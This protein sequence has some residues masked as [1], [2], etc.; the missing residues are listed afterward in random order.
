MSE[1]PDGTWFQY[2][3]QAS[4]GVPGMVIRS[5]ERAT[6]DS[7][8]LKCLALPFLWADMPTGPLTALFPFLTYLYL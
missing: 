6:S 8:S 1:R 5:Y 7:V 2:R 3:Y 4:R